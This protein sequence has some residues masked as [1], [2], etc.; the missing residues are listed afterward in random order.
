MM[1]VPFLG[2]VPIDPKFSE[3]ADSGVPIVD[4]HPDSITATAFGKIAETIK[5]KLPHKE[6]EEAPVVESKPCPGSGGHHHHHHHGH[7][8]GGHGGGC[9]HAHHHHK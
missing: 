9:S 7:S 4:L 5:N 8:E 3:A 6:V 1:G 2:S